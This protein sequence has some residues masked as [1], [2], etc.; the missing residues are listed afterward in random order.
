V[1]FD[2]P[3]SE[4][5][6]R[7]RHPAFGLT[8]G[9]HFIALI[10]VQADSATYLKSTDTRLVTLFKVAKAIANGTPPKTGDAGRLSTDE[11]LSGEARASSR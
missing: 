10:E 9:V 4:Q 5:A 7:L 1:F 3:E 6:S 11:L 8:E 2:D